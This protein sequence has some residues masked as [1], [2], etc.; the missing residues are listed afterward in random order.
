MDEDMTGQPL[1]TDELDL[2]ILEH[3]AKD[4]EMQFKNIAK[5]LNVDQR[6]IAKRVNNMK[7][8]GLIKNKIEIDWSRLGFGMSAYVGSETGLRQGDAAKL[9]DFIRKE[10]RVI[11]AYETIGDEEYFMQIVE[12]N[13]QS[14]RSEVLRPLEPLTADL[15]SSIIS[16]KIKTGNDVELLRFIRKRRFQLKKG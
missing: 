5:S 9:Y 16:S 12:E 15:T 3:L 13:I 1:V 10:P 4:A 7:E 11:A 6:T 2:E 8:S 14:L